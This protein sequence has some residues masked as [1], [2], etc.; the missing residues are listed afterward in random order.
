M[1]FNKS[2]IVFSSIMLFLKRFP[3]HQ[4]EDFNTILV[5]SIHNLSHVKGTMAQDQVF[6]TILQMRPRNKK[7]EKEEDPSHS[8]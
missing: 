8:M 6:A 4:K 5:P 1:K 2:N 7:I 3:C